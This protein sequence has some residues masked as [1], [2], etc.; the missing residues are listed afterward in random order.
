MTFTPVTHPL[1]PTTAAPGQLS[2]VETQK[3]L[4]LVDQLLA[5]RFC[6]F[7]NPIAHSMSPN[8]VQ[9]R[10]QP[11][12]PS[13]LLVSY[14]RLETDQVD[15]DVRSTL[16]HPDF[17]GVSVTIPLKRDIMSPLDELTPEAKAIGAVNTATPFTKA[18]GHRGLLGDNTDWIGTRNVVK[19]HLPQSL[20][21]VNS[22][23]VI[24]ARG[25]RA[26]IYA[27]HALGAGRSTCSNALGRA[28]KNSCTR[29]RTLPLSCST[30]ST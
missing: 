4:H 19:A 23:L 24:G 29:S 8:I 16:A 18:G 28:R 30:R 21:E 5:K 27:L 7:R 13:A 22:C 26:V 11:S 10:L 9:H 25:A 15:A 1:L 2:L 20:N 3:A 12:G 17:G 6:I 14:G